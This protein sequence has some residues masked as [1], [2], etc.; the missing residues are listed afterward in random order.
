MLVLGRE[1]QQEVV[2]RTPEGRT[3]I[4]VVTDFRSNKV[5]LGFTADSDVIIDRAEVFEQK[6]GTRPSSQHKHNDH[7]P[8]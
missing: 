2:I 4:V 3:I 8:K 5:R 7:G 1:A 6:F